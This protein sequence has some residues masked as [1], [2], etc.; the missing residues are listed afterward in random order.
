MLSSDRN[1]ANQAKES[2][3]EFMKNPYSSGMNTELAGST[4]IIA[5]KRYDQNGNLLPLRR[6]KGTAAHETGHM[7]NNV[8]GFDFSIPTSEGFRPNTNTKLGEMSE[9]LLGSKLKGLEQWAKS[10][11]ELHADLWKFRTMNKIGSRDLTEKEVDKFI[12]E[13]GNKHFISNNLNK[14]KEVIKLMPA[15]G[16]IYMINKTNDKN[17]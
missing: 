9:P 8:Y 15:I 12:K 16:G 13:Y 6:I 5:L 4:N 14:I 3:L 11:N 17:E 2:L 1:L 10:P 7:M